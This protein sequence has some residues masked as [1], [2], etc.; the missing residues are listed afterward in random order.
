MEYT[1]TVWDPHR[2]RDVYNLEQV[3]RRPARFVHRNYTE[4]TPGCVTYMVQCR[5]WCKALAGSPSNMDD[6]PVP[7]GSLCCS[8]STMALLTSLQISQRAH[9]VNITSPQRRCN[10]TWRKFNVA[11]TSI[12]RHDDASTLRRR[13]IYV[14]CLPGSFNRMINAPEDPNVYVRFRPQTT[15]SGTLIIQNPRDQTVLFEL[16]RLWIIEN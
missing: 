8:S 9:D 16:L 12:Q 14:M 10:G 7:T 15:Y 5:T 1:S 4:R 3:Q 13:Y 6:I 2:V 11:S